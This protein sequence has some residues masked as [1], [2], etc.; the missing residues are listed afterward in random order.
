V[1]R[2]RGHQ[3]EF[4]SKYVDVMP[5]DVVQDLVAHELAHGI[6]WANGIRLER[7]YSDGRAVYACEDGSPFGGKFELELDADEMMNFWGFD[8]ESVDRWA[9]AAGITKVTTFADSRKALEAMFRRM[10]RKGR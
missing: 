4:R 6:Q 3:Y 9:L 7:Q 5:D 2:E 10:D 8:S 1:T